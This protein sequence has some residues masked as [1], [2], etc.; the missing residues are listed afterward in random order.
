M[1]ASGLLV[2]MITFRA[3]APASVLDVSVCALL[4]R[5]QTRVLLSARQCD[6][7]LSTV[8]TDDN[9]C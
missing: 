3:L 1:C 7:V 9:E 8:E 5:H 4:I 2:L 6:K